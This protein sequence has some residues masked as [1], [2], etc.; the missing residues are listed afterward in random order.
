M[1]ICP[2][3]KN[4]F[5]QNSRKYTE[6]ASHASAKVC[7][8]CVRQIRSER[9]LCLPWILCETMTPPQGI[10][11]NSCPFVVQKIP[12]DTSQYVEKSLYSVVIL[13]PSLVILFPRLV[14]L[15]PRHGIL[16]TRYGICI[17]KAWYFYC[18]H[19]NKFYRTVYNF[20]LCRVG[21]FWTCLWIKM[22][23]KHSI[24]FAR[25]LEIPTF[26]GKE[27]LSLKQSAKFFFLFGEFRK[28]ASRWERC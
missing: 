9:I 20:Y 1:S 22:L 11:E 14:I 4:H 5:T 19:R 23:R 18:W 10:S 12:V 21:Y 24:S 13:F 27:R 28:F 25:I 3:V 17:T 15:F 2:S 6:F 16:V 26:C 7:A 8:V